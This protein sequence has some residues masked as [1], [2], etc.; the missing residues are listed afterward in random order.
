MMDGAILESRAGSIGVLSCQED[1]FVLLTVRT[2][3]YIRVHVPNLPGIHTLLR[4]PKN[5]KVVMSD[6][7]YL[8]TQ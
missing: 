8:M 3:T 4:C 6:D 7:Y 2:N 1:V 5:N